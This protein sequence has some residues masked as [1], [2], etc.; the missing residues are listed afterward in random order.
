MGNKIFIAKDAIQIDYD[1]IKYDMNLKFAKEIAFDPCYKSFT[2]DDI[3]EK[4]ESI[5]K[6]DFNIPH[7][8]HPVIN[9]LTCERNDDG[10]IK[11]VKTI[12]DF[13]N[14]PLKSFIGEEIIV[15]K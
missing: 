12:F 2:E 6:N 9:S 13:N 7:I 10:S 14:K 1:K 4:I 15:Y 3:C 5:I 11:K 8:G